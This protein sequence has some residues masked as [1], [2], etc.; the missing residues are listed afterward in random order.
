LEE[1]KNHFSHAK[2]NENNF[3]V[4]VVVVENEKHS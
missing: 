4:V 1:A 2:T 3:V